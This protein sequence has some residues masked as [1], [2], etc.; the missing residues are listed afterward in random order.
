MRE[1]RAI[2]G[3]EWEDKEMGPATPNESADARPISSG[4]MN[5]L[6]VGSDGRLHWDGRPVEVQQH[7]RFSWLQALGAII[8]AI[9]ALTTSLKDGHEFGC[10]MDLWSKG[11][12]VPKISSSA[13]PHNG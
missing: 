4:D 5:R 6:S 7:I 3:A 8:I 12:P 11:C 10:S 9:A 2:R 1:F 13:A